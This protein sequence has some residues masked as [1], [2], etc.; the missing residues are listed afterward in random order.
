VTSRWI[1]HFVTQSSRELHAL[2]PVAGESVAHPAARG[3]R[4]APL[5]GSRPPLEKLKMTIVKSA[6]RLRH[7]LVSA[8]VLASA[9]A[10]LP[11]SADAPDAPA[12][13]KL[14]YNDLNLS[15][16]AGVKVLYSRIQGA[17]HKVCEPLS[18]GRR[19]EVTIAWENCVS[20]AVSHAVK[21]IG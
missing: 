4:P 19:L 5:I 9:A 16:T 7:V 21:S 20:G 12:S 3:D 1:Q 2:R 13:I 14:N 18:T 10:A 17:A 6:P 11:A 15:H 8:L